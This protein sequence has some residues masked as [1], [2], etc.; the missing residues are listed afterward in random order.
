LR[1]GHDPSR[2]RIARRHAGSFS[3]KDVEIGKMLPS[4]VEPSSLSA[5]VVDGSST[6]TLRASRRPLALSPQTNGQASMSAPALPLRWDSHSRQNSQ[7]SV[8]HAS[9]SSPSLGLKTPSLDNLSRTNTLVDKEAI[10]AIKVAVDA[11][12]RI[13]DMI[14]EIL[15]DS[16][17]AREE[18]S[19]TLRRAREV[20]DKLRINLDA[21]SRGDTSADRTGIREDAHV[22]VKIVVQLSNA[23]K[24]HGTSHPLSSALRNHLVKLTTATQESVILLHVSSFSPG[25]SRAFSPMVG[26]TTPSSIPEDGRIG[27]HL[28]RSRST[29]APSIP[30]SIR[31]IR[32]PPRSALPHQSFRIPT[33]PRFGLQRSRS[34]ED[35]PAV[36]G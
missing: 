24:M 6:P 33:P 15:E 3:L 21:L 27:A 2:I 29:A 14:E 28:S 9:T 34:E 4:F 35:P 25:P 10:E 26:T 17:E 12:P 8:M 32:E 19:D 20:T 16:Q 7:N 23:V 13:W 11:A 36:P 5:G 22:F 31:P 30:R 18:F 1:N